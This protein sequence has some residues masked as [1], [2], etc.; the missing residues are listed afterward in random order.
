MEMKQ[1]GFLL[2][3]AAF[4]VFSLAGISFGQGDIFVKDGLG[5]VSKQKWASGEIIVKF[6]AGVS[7]DVI[8]QT[9]LSHGC[10]TLY[11]SKRGKFSR[12]RIS[13]NRTVEEM[14]SIYSQNPNV[15]YAEPNFIVSA[16]FTPDD[17]YYYPYQWNLHDSPGGIN[18]ESAWDISQGENVIVAVLDTGVAYENT[19]G[20]NRYKLAPDLANTTF[21]PGWDFINNDSHP[22][23]DNSHGTHVTGTIAQSTHNGMGTAGV[24]YKASIMPVKVLDSTGFGTDANV[25]DGIYYAA[26]NGAKVI[27][28]S[29]GGTDQ[30]T[31]MEDA[32]EYAYNRGVTIVCGAGNSYLDGNPTFYPAAYDAYC[33]AVGATQYDET[34]AFYSGTGTFVDIAAPGGN[35]YFDQNGDGYGDGILQQT[36][37]PNSKNTSDFGYWFFQGTSM[38]TPHVA[39]VAA[40][41]IANGITGPDNV[42]LAIE[43]T[44]KDLGSPGWDVEHGWGLVNAYAALNYVPQEV[45]DVAVTDISV[46]SPLLPGIVSV[47]VNVANQ[48][49][50]E[51]SFEVTMYVD[52]VQVGESQLVSSLPARGTTSLEFNWSAVVIGPHTLRAEVSEVLEET[53]TANNSMVATVTVIE[54]R[55]DVAVMLI[56]APLDA[57]QGDFI[58]PVLWVVNYGTY[59]ETTTVSLYDETYGVPI[60][61]SLT[62]DIDVGDLAFIMFDWDTTGASIG[63]HT[64]RGE[65][66]IADEDA[67]TLNNSMTTTTTIKQVPDGPTMHISDISMSLRQKGPN[68]QAIAKVTVLDRSGSVVDGATVTGEW[69]LYTPPLTVTPLNSIS[70]DTNGKGKAKLSSSTVKATSG[71]YFIVTITGVIKD[72]YLYDLTKNVESSDG[73]VV[74]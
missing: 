29:L 53:N 9:N 3:L 33:I 50:L 43:S 41:L 12:L 48:G 74:P 35:L 57:T 59:S 47:N 18:M 27:N 2:I 42:R 73:I 60:D 51:E 1:R 13:R 68:Y 23:D 58:Q 11:I 45:H 46:P 71:D 38:A 49:T 61:S 14:V 63:E 44:A 62:L 69:V 20:R 5:T 10:S 28:M 52:G 7:Q 70:G 16:L 64:I 30:S 72:G 55:H 67:D 19:N 26:D 66:S 34:R 54:P 36:F 22:N 31:K 24:A 17:T 25:A 65:A 56:S 6:K 32:L 15:E 37:N 39:G 40:L 4:L 8:R 21:V